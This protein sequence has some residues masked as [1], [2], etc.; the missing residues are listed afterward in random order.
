MKNKDIRTLSPK[1]LS[2]LRQ[3]VV[4]AV[5]NKGLSFVDA[6]ALFGHQRV[7]AGL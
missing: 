2:D 4:L 6:A 7:G 1:A 3:R 5:V